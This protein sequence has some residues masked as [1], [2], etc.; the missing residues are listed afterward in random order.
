MR[1]EVCPFSRKFSTTAWE[2]SYAAR[3]P[4]ERPVGVEAMAGEGD[5]ASTDATATDSAESR[6]EPVH[7][8]TD[9]PSLVDLL[10]TALSGKSWEAFSRG[11]A[12]R[13]AGRAGFARNV[14]VALGNWLAEEDEPPSEAVT[15][16]LEALSEPAPLVRGHAAWALGRSPS[17]AACSEL[18]WRASVEEDLWVRSEIMFALEGSGPTR[19]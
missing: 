5:A 2:P 3:G 14:C 17:V 11:S 15:V 13:R 4:G 7:P 18:E 9:G 12:I 8:G 10:R 6:G 19:K 16:L 1:Q